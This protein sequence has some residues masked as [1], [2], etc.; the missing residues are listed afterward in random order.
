MRSILATLM[1]LSLGGSALADEP[2]PPPPKEMAA[3]P[4]GER[5]VL[6][7][8]RL[9][10]RASLEIDLSSGS[11][12]DPVGLSPDVFYG[13]SDALTIGLVHSSVG[14]LGLIG[15]T[16]NSLCFTEG[17]DG[18][19]HNF[20]ID[21]RYQFKTGTV[22]AAANVGL[23]ARDI[24]PFTLSLKLGAVGRYRPKPSSKLAIDFQPS[25]SIG[26]TQREPAMVMMVS[27]P[28]NTE[29]FAL[30]ITAL[31]EVKPRIT[32]LVQ[33]GLV[34]PFESAGDLFFVPLSLGGSYAINKQIS[35]E[36]AFTLQALLGGDGIPNGF[37]ARSFTIGGGY[38]F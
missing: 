4:M 27:I 22:A 7:A 36:A 21:A 24:D 11:A 30:P 31:Y 28:G 12:G 3:G 26:I 34:L 16:G 14:G 1:L 15:G 2:P 33:T 10:A 9:Y 18:V 13:V 37:N 32:V 20:G 5:V 19:Y 35:V 23:V 8:K 38:A 17:C 29:I 25:L 6:P